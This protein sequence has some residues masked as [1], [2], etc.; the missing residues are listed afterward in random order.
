MMLFDNNL[1]STDSTLEIDLLSIFVLLL[2]GV[3]SKN[4]KVSPFS[5]WDRLL[6][7]ILGEGFVTINDA[8]N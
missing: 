7:K 5:D 3:G 4:Q 6:N 8:G 1:S 2:E